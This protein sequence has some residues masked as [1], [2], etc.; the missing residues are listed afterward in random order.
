MYVHDPGQVKSSSQP[1]DLLPFRYVLYY[2]HTQFH[3]PSFGDT[4]VII[5]TEKAKSFVKLSDCYFTFYSN[6]LNKG[7]TI[8]LKSII[9]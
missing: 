7:S 1:Q 4:S 6:L 8:F 5:I 2:L 3:K 9:T